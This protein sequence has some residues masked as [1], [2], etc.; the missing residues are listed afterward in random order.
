MADRTHR[1][2]ARQAREAKRRFARMGIKFMLRPQPSTASET[3]RSGGAA[4]VSRRTWRCCASGCR[5]SRCL[6][7]RS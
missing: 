2:L 1:D 4:R 6:P 7:A 5:R 3:P